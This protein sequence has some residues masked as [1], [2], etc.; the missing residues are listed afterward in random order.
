MEV[1]PTKDP[2]DDIA[3]LTSAVGMPAMD[4]QQ[5]RQ[6]EKQKDQK[7]QSEVDDWEENADKLVMSEKVLNYKDY[8]NSK[9]RCNT[10]AR[11]KRPRDLH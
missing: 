4:K 9:T 1:T 3:R 11:A 6:E 5:T 2:D 8:A 7:L 10:Q